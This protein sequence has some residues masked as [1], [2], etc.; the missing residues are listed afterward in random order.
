M[1]TIGFPIH[2]NTNYQILLFSNYAP[3]YALHSF[4]FMGADC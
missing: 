1:K 4:Y 2:L 3:A